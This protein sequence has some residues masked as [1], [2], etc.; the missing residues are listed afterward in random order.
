MNSRWTEIIRQVL[1]A[2]DHRL[3]ERF[4][5]VQLRNRAWEMYQTGWREMQ[6]LAHKTERTADECDRYFLSNR[7][8][9]RSK[10]MGQRRQLADGVHQA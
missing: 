3:S 1:R 6:L 2:I 7:A 10:W 8:E 5:T 4:S 9:I